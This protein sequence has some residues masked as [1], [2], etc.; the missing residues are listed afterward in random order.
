MLDIELPTN[1][2]LKVVEAPEAVKG[3]S[4]NNPSKKI[5]LETGFEIEAPM[6][7]KEGEMIVVSSET[8]KYVGRA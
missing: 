7:I 1:I 4:A 2:E 5:K 3:N 6:F 8:G